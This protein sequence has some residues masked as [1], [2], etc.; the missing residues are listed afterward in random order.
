MNLRLAAAFLLLLGTTVSSVGEGRNLEIS[1][2]HLWA[3][4]QLGEGQPVTAAGQR[5]SVTRL[6][7]LLSEFEL[8]PEQGPVVSLTNQFAFVSALTGPTRFT[9]TGIPAVRI[10]ALRFRVGLNPEVNHTDPAQFPAGHP[11]NPSRNGLHWNWQGGYVFLAL[12]GHWNSAGR[13]DDSGGFSFHVA[14]D[15]LVMP[16][17]IPVELDLAD[18]PEIQVNCD[19]AGLFA[20]SPPLRLTPETC[21]THSRSGDRLA[22]RLADPIRQAFQF[23]RSGSFATAAASPPKPQTEMA[24]AAPPYR[25]RISRFFP[26]PNLPKDNPLTEPGVELGRRLFEEPRLSRSGQQSCASC[27]QSSAALVDAGQQ[28]SRGSDG[29]LGTR[30]S[31]TL[32]N[33]AWQTSFFWDGRAST[34][35]EQVLQPI[36]NPLEMHETL[37]NVVAK[38]QAAGFGPA[39]ARAFGSPEITSDRMARALEQFLLTQVSHDSRF[40]RSLRSAAVLTEEEKRGFELFHTEYD[41]AHGQFGADCFHCHGGALFTDGAFHNN[42]LDAGGRARDTGRFLITTNRMDEAKFKTPSLRN[43]ELTAPYMHDGRFETLED[44]VRH[45]VG[46]VQR[47]P[48]LD[49]NLAKHPAGGVPLSEVDQK[50]LVAFLKSLTDERYRGDPER[51]AQVP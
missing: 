48:T 1:L 23:A 9:L 37:T 31:M 22:K 19:L 3:G 50:A 47:S 28:V 18:V 29:Q 2:Q 24:P 36:E 16:I 26:Q 41:P 46:G 30:N 33:L 25:L 49:P 45:Y 42:G 44:V 43:V 34:L 40:D 21:S 20:D 8:V 27:H 4:G 39:F 5:V 13:D 38:L 12:E 32:L 6:D 17:E 10:S 11:L 51:V 15:S 7:Y 35:R 14:T